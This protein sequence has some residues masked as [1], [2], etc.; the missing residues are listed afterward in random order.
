MRIQK[1]NKY[2][3]ISLGVATTIPTIK[4]HLDE[5]ISQADKALYFAK[6]N[7]RNCVRHSSYDT[8]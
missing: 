5:L 1:L 8:A 2:I 7:G 4:S 3:T 6:K